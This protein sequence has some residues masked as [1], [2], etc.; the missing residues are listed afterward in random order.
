MEENKCKNYNYADMNNCSVYVLRFPDGKVYVGMTARPVEDRWRC[1]QG[2]HLSQTLHDEIMRVGWENIVTEVVASGLSWDDA[3]NIED[4]WIGKL[5]ADNPDRGYNKKRRGKNRGNFPTGINLDEIMFRRDKGMVRKKYKH[6]NFRIG[7]Y[8]YAGQLERVFE[9]L[10][11][12]V[13]NNEVG[14]TYKGILACVKHEIK[15]HAG[16][17]WRKEGEE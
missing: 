14:A 13:E 5:N 1:G 9:N 7:M 6:D 15:K 10:T 3:L 17:I 16:K 4:N 12:A 2:Y 8:N 11:D